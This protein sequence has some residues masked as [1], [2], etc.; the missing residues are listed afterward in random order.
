MKTLHCADAGF[1]CD[2]VVQATTEEEVLLQ[3][4]Q[5]AKSVHHV[6]ITPEMALQ[7]KMLI[8]DEAL[9]PA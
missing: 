1:A 3:A 4:A 7:I 8:K 6:E 5:H 9:P 2:A